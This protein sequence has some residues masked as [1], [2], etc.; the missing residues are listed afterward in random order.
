MTKRR[1]SFWLGCVAAAAFLIA[2][3]LIL[4]RDRGPYYHGKPLDTYWFHEL[5]ISSIETNS[6]RRISAH[7]LHGHLY[8]QARED[9]ATVDEAILAMGTN[10]L[11]FLLRKLDKHDSA[12]RKHVEKWMDKVG[13]HS[14]PWR[15]ADW[16]RAQAVTALFLLGR[17]RLVTPEAL[18]RIQELSKSS[19]T[20]VAA[21]AK[22]LLQWAL[23]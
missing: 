23:P 22:F 13:I 15:D 14:T 19:D 11:P 16:E 10:C 17:N 6:S 21:S 12:F 2:L 5:S 3:V 4:S 1:K 20:N 7:A 8:G 18:K 9:R